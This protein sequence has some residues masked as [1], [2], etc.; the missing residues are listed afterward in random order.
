MKFLWSFG[1]GGQAPKPP[2]LFPFFCPITLFSCYTRL[3]SVSF[4]F[5]P[6]FTFSWA[7]FNFSERE[8]RGGLGIFLAG[9]IGAGGFGIFGLD[10]GFVCLFACL[11]GL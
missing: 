7:F 10:G 5:R 9:E 2:L 3:W 8:T 6:L 11:S 4:A 1:R